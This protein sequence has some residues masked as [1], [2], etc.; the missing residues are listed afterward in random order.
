M[1][2]LWM[3]QTGGRGSESVIFIREGDRWE[4]GDLEERV[5]KLDGDLGRGC[6]GAPGGNRQQHDLRMQ[7]FSSR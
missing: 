4:K 2:Q 6:T 5:L 1:Q 7:V 3:T